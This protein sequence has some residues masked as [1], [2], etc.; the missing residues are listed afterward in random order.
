MVE[1]SAGRYTL[2]LGDLYKSWFYAVRKREAGV[3]A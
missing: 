1:G 2:A 3:A